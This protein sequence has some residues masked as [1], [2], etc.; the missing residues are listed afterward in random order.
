MTSTKDW[1]GVGLAPSVS[2]AAATVLHVRVT[3]SEGMTNNALLRAITSY[4]FAPGGGAVA[5][6]ALTVTPEPVAYPTYVDVTLDTHLTIGSGNYTVTVNAGL[7]DKA[8][9]T[10]NPAGLSA[11]FDGVA[12]QDTFVVLTIPTSLTRLRVIYSWPVKQVNP[13]NPDDA[14]NPANY[15]VTGGVTVTSVSTVS[16]TEVELVVSGQQYGQSYTMGISNVEDVSNNV[17][18]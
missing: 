5:V 2:S 14:L 3:F 9:N 4:A 16:S 1:V 17:I 13:A 8:G 15:T 11:V 7:V 10:I 12:Y 6:N 18:S